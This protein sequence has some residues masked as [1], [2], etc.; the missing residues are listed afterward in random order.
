[1]N[2]YESPQFVEPAS[3]LVLDRLK[4]WRTFAI[5]AIV[6]AIVWLLC[7]LVGIIVF[8]D[9]VPIWYYDKMILNVSVI[10]MSTSMGIAFIFV[11][12]L[13]W[14]DQKIQNCNKIEGGRV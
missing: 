3:V 7:S 8:H 11:G 10:S 13:E 12:I 14:V 5:A 4:F 1:M 9:K 2:P 6:T